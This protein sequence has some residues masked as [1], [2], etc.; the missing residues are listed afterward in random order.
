MAPRKN[1]T[2][3]ASAVKYTK[4]KRTNNQ[5]L[6]T[7]ETSN[8]APQ[9]EITL[10][11]PPKKKG[12]GPGKVV[13]ST[14]DIADRP[15]IWPI[16]EHEFTCDGDAWKIV[17]SITR[18]ALNY[19][20]SPLRSYHSFDLQTKN[21]V[22]K[23]FLERFTYREG[24]DPDRC[25]EVLDGIA[26]K[27]YGEEMNTA[28]DKCFKAFGRDIDKWKGMVP[29]W[30]LNAKYWHELCDI[31]G[32]DEWQGLSAQNKSNRTTSGLTVSH[33][34]GSASAHQTQKKLKNLLNGTEPTKE[35][36]YLHTHCKLPNGK[37]PVL[38]Q[39]EASI[40][41]ASQPTDDGDS[42][43]LVNQSNAGTTIQDNPFDVNSFQFT[44][45]RAQDV[46]AQ[47]LSSDKPDEV[48][49]G[50]MHPNLQVRTKLTKQNPV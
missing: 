10:S 23:A 26:G 33:F 47:A 9:G 42:N 35:Q 41:A 48:V 34:G 16:G 40:A 15:V 3:R 17:K 31:F 11:Q 37:S 36:L 12:R 39:I 4:R 18:L 46:Y 8:A 50:N 25:R 24:E 29:H 22:E 5:Q 49:V 13:D 6:H 30:C 20:P 28:R 43:G 45:K 19:M 27:R 21:A 14:A 2:A 38:A 7:G 44:N 32:T 1:H